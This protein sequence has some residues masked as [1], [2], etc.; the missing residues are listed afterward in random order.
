MS[1][2]SSR[3]SP[4]R[5]MRGERRGRKNAKTK[6]AATRRQIG[7]LHLPEPTDSGEKKATLE[8]RNQW[9]LASLGWFN[10]CLQI[11][12]RRIECG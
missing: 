3:R 8:I 1:I 11:A 5:G 6:E 9:L 4:Q 2:L 7:V 12:R 10:G